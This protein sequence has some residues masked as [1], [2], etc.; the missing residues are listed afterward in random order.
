MVM[1]IVTG[2]KRRVIE[3]VYRK[4][5]G[6]KWARPLAQHD[7]W[8]LDGASVDASGNLI[9][10]GLGTPIPEPDGGG[11]A[12]LRSIVS[13]VD[14]H[15]RAEADFSI[16]PDDVRI[17]VGGI[18][19]VALSEVDI[20]VVHEVFAELSYSFENSGEFLVLDV[21]ANIGC[22]SLYFASRYGA[23]VWAYELV[24]ST[25]AIATR[26]LEMNPELASRIKF[27]PFGLGA[28]NAKL[29]IAVDPAY[30]PSN[31]L[32]DSPLSATQQTEPVEVRDVSVEM[33]RALHEKGDRKLV[34]K[35]DAEGAEYEILERL[36]E[37]RLLGAFDLVLLEWHQKSGS[38]P[39]RLKELLRDAGFKWFERQHPTSPVG[40]I[41]AYR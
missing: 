16:L 11:M 1:R 25:A 4:R 22:A 13:C 26:N 35:I 29:E 23:E 14:L 37:G 3:A 12:V 31:S 33:E 39:D 20:G 28:A 41:N 6:R 40:Y 17:N 15:R 19:M 27:Y 21:G 9:V 34:A 2:L 30:R 8:P 38:D 18:K 36:S 7:I 5:L 10:P 32:Y 24:P